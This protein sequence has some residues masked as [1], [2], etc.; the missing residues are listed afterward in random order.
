MVDISAAHTPAD[1]LLYRPVVETNDITA[2]YIEQV[3]MFQK[4]LRLV[5]SRFDSASSNPAGG[6]VGAVVVLFG[7]L[8]AFPHF[9]PWGYEPVFLIA[10]LLGEVF[11]GQWL[12]YNKLVLRGCTICGT[13]ASRNWEILSNW[14][15]AV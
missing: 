13:T 5:A 14:L 10:V 11:P 1:S 15:T 4:T 9:L 2:S 7:R 6:L 3:E 8:R 12:L